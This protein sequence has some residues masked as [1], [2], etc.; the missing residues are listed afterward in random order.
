MTFYAGQ[1]GPFFWFVFFGPA[2]KMNNVVSI[3]IGQTKTKKSYK[4]QYKNNEQIVLATTDKNAFFATLIEGDHKGR[5]YRF[6]FFGPAKKMNK[7]IIIL[8]RPFE[9]ELLKNQ[10]F[11]SF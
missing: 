11:S 6:V 9:P 10:F 2:K 3:E 4:K 7:R 8:N 5:P 1:K